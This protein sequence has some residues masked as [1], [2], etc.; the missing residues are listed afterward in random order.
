MKRMSLK[1][2]ITLW[3]T[4]VMLA[5]SAVLLAVTVSVSQG[6]LE[7]T[8]ADKLTSTVNDFSR[9]L[10]KPCGGQQPM[11]EKGFYENGIHMAVYG[12]NGELIAGNIPFETDSPGSIASGFSSDEK[13]GEKYFI[14]KKGVPDER[15]PR[16]YTVGIVPLSAESFALES[17]AKTNAALVIVMLLIAAGG[18]YLIISKALAPVKKISGTAKKI[19]ESSDLTQRIN[20]PGGGDEIHALADT[21]DDMLD[22]IGQLVE[23]EKQFTADASH[24][25]RTPAAVIMSECEYMTDCDLSIDEMKESA[26]SIK[27]QTERM[28]KLISELLMISR[29][30]KNTIAAQF[31]EVD[32]SELLGFVCDEQEEL[33]GCA[34]RLS[35]NI[36]PEITAS[37]DRGLMTRLFIN[38][39]SNA[40]SYI[41]NGDLISVSLYK[42]GGNVIFETE[43]NGIGI[44]EEDLPKIWERFYRSDKSRTAENSANSGLGLSMVKWIAELHGGKVSAESTYGSGSKF[45]FSMPEK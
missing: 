2:K 25:L 14:Y 9:R 3:Y 23:K 13:D 17:T 38:I 37:A 34:V 1:L 31:E 40:Y 6:M 26:E 12:E 21:F 15:S 41:G 11:P 16:M 22:K 32:L 24:E 5:V 43:D 19:S 7:K 29:M 44:T 35:R 18:G 10:F 20:L 36:T 39:I 8:V 42:S 30:D 33:H 4:A 27:R 28:T 45:I